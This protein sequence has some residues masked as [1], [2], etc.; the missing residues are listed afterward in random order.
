MT[1]N[2]FMVLEYFQKLQRKINALYMDMQPPV[3]LSTFISYYTYTYNELISYTNY[4]D[5][6]PK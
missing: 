3:L 4:V 2:C 6:S 1:L 5:K